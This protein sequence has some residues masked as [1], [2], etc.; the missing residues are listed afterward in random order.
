M[1]VHKIGAIEQISDDLMFRCTVNVS[2]YLNPPP[3]NTTATPIGA[4]NTNAAT[5]PGVQPNTA[6]IARLNIIA[7]LKAQVA[8]GGSI[9]SGFSGPI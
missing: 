2:E 6:T 1:F 4:K 7:R 9:P 5:S 3:V 8:A